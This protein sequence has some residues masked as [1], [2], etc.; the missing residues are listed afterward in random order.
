[1]ICKQVTAGAF[2]FFV[3]LF[4]KICV[5]HKQIVY[6]QRRLL[7]T[8]QAPLILFTKTIDSCLERDL[9][10]GSD[11]HKHAMDMEV[12]LLVDLPGLDM[13]FG[14]ERSMFSP[15]VDLSMGSAHP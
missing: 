4:F 11:K 8:S 7:K 15:T 5:G 10:T 13:L 1:M 6:K 9:G 2:Y 14:A 12:T 3:F